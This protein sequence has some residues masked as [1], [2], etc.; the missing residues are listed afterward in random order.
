M[1]MEAYFTD[2]TNQA[3]H[4]VNKLT[5]VFMRTFELQR[6]HTKDQMNS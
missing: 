3:S 2:P 4:Q 6:A 1:C 5:Y